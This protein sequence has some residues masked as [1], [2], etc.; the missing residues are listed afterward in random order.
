[1]RRTL[2]L[3]I[4]ALAV[5]AGSAAQAQPAPGNAQP[6]PD[7]TREQAQTMADR[8]FT[9]ADANSDGRLD[10]ADREARQRARF[11]RLDADK[12]GA[13][14]F[15]EMQDSRERGGKRMGRADGHGDRQHMRGERRRGMGGPGGGWG[16]MRQMARAADTN[17]DGAISQDG[18]PHRRA[19]AVRPGRCQWRRYG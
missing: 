14:S 9:R 18:V 11:D 4:A 6:R 17:E 8:M 15:A 19:R 3:S 7:M 5:L 2:T 13:L 12:D 16:H 10:E 1:M